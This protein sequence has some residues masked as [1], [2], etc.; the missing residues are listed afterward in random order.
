LLT[1]FVAAKK[2]SAAPHRGNANKPTTNQGKANGQKPTPKPSQQ[3]KKLTKNKT[4]KHHH[5]KAIKTKPLREQK[6]HLH[7]NPKP[8]RRQAPK[9]NEKTS[10]TP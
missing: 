7:Q 10:T 9:S 4:T 6:Y 5:S 3:R 1:F 2:V 8:T